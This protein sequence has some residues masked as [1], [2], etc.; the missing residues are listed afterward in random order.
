MNDYYTI[1]GVPRTA[2]QSEIKKAY[3]EL[4]FKYHPD[5]N[6]GDRSAEERFKKISEAYSVLSDPDKKARYDLGGFSRGGTSSST[7]S[8]SGE[9]PFQGYSWTYYGPFGGSGNWQ[10]PEYEQYTKKQAFELLLRSVLTLLA[11]TL[12]LRY[13]FFLGI[14]GLLLCLTVIGRGFINTVRAIKLLL[15]SN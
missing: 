10:R 13:S 9:N 15:Q 8:W 7:S 2:N 12:L 14:F 1:L 11:G 3:R 5:K 4:A 6:P